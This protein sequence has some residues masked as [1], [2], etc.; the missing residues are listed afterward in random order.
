MAGFIG[1][2]QS[3]TEMTLRPLV[4]WAVRRQ[5]TME[6]LLDGY[7]NASFVDAIPAKEACR[8]ELASP[9]Q[10]LEAFYER[11][12]SL[13]VVPDGNMICEFLP[14]AEHANERGKPPV[15]RIANLSE[16]RWIGIVSLVTVERLAAM[17]REKRPYETVFFIGNEATK[18]AGG[19]ANIVTTDFVALLTE[20]FNAAERGESLT[21]DTVGSSDPCDL[22]AIENLFPM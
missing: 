21:F 3:N 11:F 2:T 5:N 18:S 13:K 8:L 16:G 17:L 10:M 12:D 7:E 1:I 14:M 15:T 4:G 9:C 20:I 19:V 22:D 6:D